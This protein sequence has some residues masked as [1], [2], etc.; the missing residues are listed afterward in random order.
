MSP[1]MSNKI[2]VLLLAGV[3]LLLDTGG[4]RPSKSIVVDAGAEDCDNS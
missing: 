3:A 1:R 4:V 2:P